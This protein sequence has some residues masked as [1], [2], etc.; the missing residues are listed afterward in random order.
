VRLLLLTLVGCTQQQAPPVLGW[1]PA[2]GRGTVALTTPA[3]ERVRISLMEGFPGYT[4]GLL[5]GGFGGSAYVR[6]PAGG[7]EEG[8]AFWCA[9]DESLWLKG[10]NGGR[11]FSHGWS[12]NFGS[13]PDGTPLRLLGGAVLA[14]DASGLLLRAENGTLPFHLARWLLVLSDGTLLTRLRIANAGATPIRFAFWEG[15]DP[16]V[17]RYGTSEGDLGWWG[18][19]GQPGRWQRTEGGP[20][21]PFPRCLGIGDP[22]EGEGGPPAANFLCLAP[23]APAPDVFLFADHFAHDPAEMD[24]ERPLTSGAMVAF[25]LGWTGLALDPGAAWEVAWAAGATAPPSASQ[26]PIAPVVPPDAWARLAAEPAPPAVL[27]RDPLR[28]A[29]EAVDMT[30]LP[31]G[32]AVRI[33]GRY[34]FVHDGAEDQIRRIFFPFAVDGAHP[35]PREVQAEGR[36]LARLRDGVVFPLRVP[37]GGETTF[38]LA[39]TQDCLDASATYI[40]TTA[41]AWEQ[42][43]AESTLTLRLPPDLRLVAQSPALEAVGD[44]TWRAHFAP[45]QPEGE[46]TVRWAAR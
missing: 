21:T 38:T 11:E 27:P 40:V 41:N 9:Q 28:F 5:L 44:G 33:E 16:W 3:G 12:E 10:P 6:W 19:P 29:A 39:Y 23:E 25:N 15:E 22:G 24:P 45:F 30:V 13:G 32:G 26:A 8:V 4:G 36:T 14:N 35:W 18:S 17:G 2:T 31:G 46:W 7:P 20:S 37:A 34:T 42:P 43:L 1:D